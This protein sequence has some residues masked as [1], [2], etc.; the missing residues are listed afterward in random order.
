MPH[1]PRDE[2]PENSTQELE[3]NELEKVSGGLWGIP[4]V[5]TTT[6]TT[7]EPPPPRDPA[8]GLPTGKRQY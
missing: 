8:N 7:T 5:T 3:E 4:I 6:T 1:E 2:K